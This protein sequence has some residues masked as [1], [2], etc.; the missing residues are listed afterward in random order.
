MA[1]DGDPLTE[2]ANWLAR[3]KKVLLPIALIL[4][5]LGCAASVGDAIVKEEDQEQMVEYLRSGHI[6]Q[7]SAVKYAQLLSEHGYEL[8][9][10]VLRLD[11]QQLMTLGFLEGHAEL[12]KKANNQVQDPGGVSSTAE[13]QRGLTEKRLRKNNDVLAERLKV[14]MED[15]KVK[16]AKIDSLYLTVK[17]NE[18]KIAKLSEGAK[19][20][21]SVASIAND[22]SSGLKIP[23]AKDSKID[24][25]SN[26]TGEKNSVSLKVA[27]AAAKK[28]LETISRL[29]AK[30]EA[31]VQ[32]LAVQP[33]AVQPCAVGNN[34]A[35][36]AA[37]G[38]GQSASAQA[39][40]LN[41]I[42]HAIA[43]DGQLRRMLED[44]IVNHGS[45]KAFYS[46]IRKLYVRKSPVKIVVFGGSV[47]CGNGLPNSNYK[48]STVLETW[49]NDN[50]KIAN[51]AKHS[52]EN[53]CTSA[54]GSASLMQSIKMK[55]SGKKPDL[56]LLEFA[57][58]DAQSAT[59]GPFLGGILEMMGAGA[60]NTI[61]ACVRILQL[62]L[63][64]AAMI[65]AIDSPRFQYKTA[66]DAQQIVAS[67]YGV[68]MIS[69]RAALRPNTGYSPYF[70]CKGAALCPDPALNGWM[71]DPAKIKRCD[72]CHKEGIVVCDRPAGYV[73][74]PH[75]H[76]GWDFYGMRGVDGMHSNCIAHLFWAKQIQWAISSELIEMERGEAPT[77]GDEQD[78]GC[79]A[80]AFKPEDVA[81]IAE[82]TRWEWYASAGETNAL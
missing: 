10:Q 60:G 49:L 33:S 26:E 57:L 50:F 28:S 51:E 43:S 8:T 31:A 36:S 74:K 65:L 63:G 79:C 37:A 68:Y 54:R 61:E 82:F 25:R 19:A 29:R 24:R 22:S 13:Q 18:A 32:P 45:G 14:A 62:Q 11:K 12:L 3:R 44:S 52:V 73:S 75:P 64:T 6:N 56:V 15:N 70:G 7:R 41:G 16:V 30:L 9:E 78:P 35:G 40:V 46:F 27:Q 71:K 80:T 38:V 55:L 17:A 67:Y 23:R 47:T 5:L 59:G 77:H 34:S 42:R 53:L 1:G 72:V 66:E 39:T 2:A 69:M 21:G 4:V 58:N 76:T 48:Y 81:R 20:R